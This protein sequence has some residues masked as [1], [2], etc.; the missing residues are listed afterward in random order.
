MNFNIFSLFILVLSFSIVLSFSETETKVSINGDGQDDACFDENFGNLEVHKDQKIYPDDIM[1]Q[2]KHRKYSSGS[3]F[4]ILS[5]NDYI[6]EK[7]KRTVFHYYESPID[8]RNLTL[9]FDG[10]QVHGAIRELKDYYSS[11]SGLIR[12]WKECH[13]GSTN[14]TSQTK[15][16][17]GM[18]YYRD[19]DTGIKSSLITYDLDVSVY[20][21]N[22]PRGPSYDNECATYKTSSRINTNG[23]NPSPSVRSSTIEVNIK[24]YKR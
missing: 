24:Q 21:T 14:V 22:K 18:K 5:T 4:T 2:I 19:Y 12:E 6:L 11:S 10:V 23:K 20:P 9:L 8:P 1:I 17:Y 15:S 16:L 3:G 13:F 7:G